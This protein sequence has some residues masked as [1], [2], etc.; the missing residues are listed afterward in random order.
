MGD[1]EI[2]DSPWLETAA[3]QE[4]LTR[5]LEVGANRVPL[6]SVL[7]QMP[8]NCQSRA[9][10]SST[11]AAW[12]RDGQVWAVATHRGRRGRFASS[13]TRSRA[14]VVV[15]RRWGTGKASEACLLD[16]TGA[17]VESN[18][19]QPLRRSAP[20]EDLRPYLQPGPKQWPAS[21][22]TRGKRSTESQAY[23]VDTLTLPFDNP[24]GALMFVSGFDF[25]ANGD[26]AVSTVHGDV[27]RLSGID[28]GLE[29]LEW[30]RFATG[31]FQP[32]GVKIVDDRVYV[33]GRDQIT[34]LHDTNGDRRGRLL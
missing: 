11:V 26:A 32:L 19:K 3:G 15:A 14:S 17:G 23:V 33:V 13:W 4:L 28:A 7:A 25:F 12:Q 9:T 30:K 8:A 1:V 29:R 27:W 20:P 24:Y 34:L 6:S 2:L 31:L 16:R 22:V 18:S 10:D 5:S 21:I